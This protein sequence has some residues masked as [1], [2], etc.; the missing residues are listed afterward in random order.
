MNSTQSILAF[1]YGAKRIGVAV[2][3]QITNTAQGLTTLK[4][5]K[6]QPDWEA[7]DKLI[8]EWRPG[9]LIVGLPRNMDGSPHELHGQWQAVCRHLCGWWS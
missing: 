6:Q 9:L 3:Q 8:S 2:G 1:D 5:V 4:Q 7:I